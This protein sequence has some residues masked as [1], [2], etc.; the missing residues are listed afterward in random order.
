MLGVLNRINV[1]LLVPQLAVP[2]ADGMT[3]IAGAAGWWIGTAFCC[4]V[5]FATANSTARLVAAVFLVV[6]EYV[7][8]LAAEGSRYIELN[9]QLHAQDRYIHFIRYCRPFKTQQYAT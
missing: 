2:V 6:A 9:I 4:Y 7:A 1:P 5:P 8:G 3:P